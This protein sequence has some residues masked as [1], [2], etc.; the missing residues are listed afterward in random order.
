MAAASEGTDL[1]AK[2]GGDIWVPCR[3][4]ARVLSITRPI[5][6][7]RSF[8]VDAPWNPGAV[9]R[10]TAGPPARSWRAPVRECRRT[11]WG[12]SR[13]RLPRPSL[14]R[15]QSHL[16]EPAY[17]LRRAATQHRVGFSV[18]IGWGRRPSSAIECSKNRGERFARGV[19]QPPRP[20][21]CAVAR[22]SSAWLINPR[23]IG[24][25]S[26]VLSAAQP[27]PAWRASRFR[28]SALMLMPPEPPNGP[29]G[30]RHAVPARRP[31]QCVNVGDLAPESPVER[32]ASAGRRACQADPEIGA[33]RRRGSARTGW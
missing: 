1:P 11:P 17:D 18:E 20:G 5:L 15:R 14:A 26:H 27:R 29:R 19:R 21:T 3:P 30:P 25:P 13:S 7:S 28:W 6:A 4:P 2:P 32:G 22:K 24:H 9:A 8:P 33:I 12:R 10:V 23:C 31:G 16:V